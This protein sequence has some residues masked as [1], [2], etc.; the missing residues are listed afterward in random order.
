MASLKDD[1]RISKASEDDQPRLDAAPQENQLF[2]AIDQDDVEWLERILTGNPS[3]CDITD[4]YGCTLLHRAAGRG[5]MKC[6]RYIVEQDSNSISKQDERGCHPLHHAACN[7]QVEAVQLLLDSNADINVKNKEEEIPLFTACLSGS[8]ETVG[9]LLD[10]HYKESPSQLPPTDATDNTLLHMCMIGNHLMVKEL[11][12]KMLSL[13]YTTEQ[14]QQLVE[15]QNT[16]KQTILDMAKERCQLRTIRQHLSQLQL[17]IMNVAVKDEDQ[18]ED[19][20]TSQQAERHHKDPN[21]LLLVDGHMDR[22]DSVDSRV[23]PSTD[24]VNVLCEIVKKSIVKKQILH[25]DHKVELH[26]LTVNELPPGEQDRSLALN[27]SKDTAQQLE[28]L[29]GIHGNVLNKLPPDCYLISSIVMVK[30]AANRPLM[31]SITIPHA[32]ATNKTA[33]SKAS[34]K[35]QASEVQLYVFGQA[36]VIGVLESENYKLDLKSCTVTMVIDKQQTF[37]LTVTGKFTTHARLFPTVTTNKPLAINCIYFVLVEPND[38]YISVR[39]YCTINLPIAWKV[40]L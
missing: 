6:L 9:I 34:K 21:T 40:C 5:R 25:K 7:G 17:S 23:T 37:A 3:G 31:M 26:V 29:C 10:Q 11:L 16:A 18:N 14:L 39:V 22:N 1:S 38:D 35:H 2:E 8:F 15:S 20:F 32:L 36:G 33:T 24:G 27:R 28:L 12:K 13:G 4:K 30:L 19:V